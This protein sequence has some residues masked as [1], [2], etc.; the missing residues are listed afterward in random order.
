M[1]IHAN[2]TISSQ[3]K[4][5]PTNVPCKVQRLEDEDGYQ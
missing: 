3:G 1:N 4:G 2:M 5:I